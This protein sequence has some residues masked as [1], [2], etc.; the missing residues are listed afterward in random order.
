[1][2]ER[3]VGEAAPV[4]QHERLGGGEPVALP[5]TSPLTCVVFYKAACPTCKWAMPFVQRL[6]ELTGKLRVVGIASDTPDDAAAFAA[7]LELTF[8]IGLE[9]EP[10][11]T[12]AAWGLQSVPTLF[13]LGEGG[14]IVISSTGFSRDDFQEVARRAAELDGAARPSDP[15]DGREMPAFRPG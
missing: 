15:F 3:Q 14:E 11:E 6:H 5:G 13:L 10:W 1:M 7:D 12:S 4:S 8:E 2:S 9:S